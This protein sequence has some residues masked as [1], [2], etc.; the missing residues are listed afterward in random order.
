MT[1][2]SGPMG[3]CSAALTLGLAGIF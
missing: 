3:L 1:Q 2:T